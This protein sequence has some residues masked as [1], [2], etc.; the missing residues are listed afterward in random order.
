MDGWEKFEETD[1]PP[2]EAF[3]S[4]LNMQGISDADYELA[5]EVW[6]TMTEKTVGKYHDTYLKKEVLLLSDVFEKFRKTCLEHYQLDPVH[7]YTA[8]GLAWKAALKHTKFT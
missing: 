5:I 8:P 1:L 6:K 7:F 4:K 2:K 3:Y